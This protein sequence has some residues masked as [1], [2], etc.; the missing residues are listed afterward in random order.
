[1][2]Y[3]CKI[4]VCSSLI[5]ACKPELKPFEKSDPGVIYTA[6][7]RGSPAKIRLSIFSDL[8]GGKHAVDVIIKHC[9]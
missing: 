4:R 1:M 7:L 9:T 5:A 6:L 8:R 3:V 2:H